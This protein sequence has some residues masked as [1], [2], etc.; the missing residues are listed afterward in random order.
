MRGFIVMC[1]CA[2]A[3]AAP[4]GYNYNAQGVS[5]GNVFQQHGNF[6]SNFGGSSIGS[7]AGGFLQ[8]GHAV[9][10]QSQSFAGHQQ[11]Q[12]HH[13][14]QAIVSKRFFI[15]SAPEDVEEDTQEKHITIGVP[16]KNYNVVFIKSPSKSTKKTSIKISP[17]PT[18]EKTVIY[19]LN[20]KTDASDIQ[21]EVVEHPTTT[22]KPEVFFI[23]YKTNEEAAHAQEQI[24]AQYDALGGS[25][26]VSDEGVAPVSSVIGALGNAAAG[27]DI[28]SGVNTGSVAIGGVQSAGGNFAGVSAGHAGVQQTNSNA[29]LPPNFY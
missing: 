3:L 28:N 10:Q 13:Q 24:Q 7:V 2:V 23:K 21:A 15:H 5:G 22:A 16:K 25:S 4:Q 17:A 20:K 12:Q 8:G 18:E 26:Q 27:G 9:A 11:V 14:Q 29:Y 6:G 19:V 1:L